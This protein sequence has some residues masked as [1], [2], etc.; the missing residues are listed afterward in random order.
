MLVGNQ[1]D[2]C[3][4]FYVTNSF[5]FLWLDIFVFSFH[6]GHIWSCP[7]SEG[8][9]YIFHCHPPEQK[10]PKHRRLVE[11]Y[12]KML[13]KSKV[14]NVIVEYKV[15]LKFVLLHKQF[16]F[17]NAKPEGF[18]YLLYS[19]FSILNRKKE[20]ISIEHGVSR[21][22]SSRIFYFFK[23]LKKSVCSF[24][25]SPYIMWHMWIS[26]YHINWALKKCQMMQEQSKI[27]AISITILN[28]L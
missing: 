26:L 13:D 12:K 22:F 14:D 19:D 7:P 28:Y 20:S 5:I 8:D 11:W 24:F 18:Q 3:N 4:L 16:V 23:V 9:D 6:W 21:Y 1:F 27:M 25:L 17:V 2:N 10:I 15:T